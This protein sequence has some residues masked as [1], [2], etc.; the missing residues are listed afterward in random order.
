[1]SWILPTGIDALV[2][3]AALA[4]LAAVQNPIIPI[5]REREVGHIVDEASVDV[6]IVVPGMARLRLP[7]P[8]RR[9]ER[10]PTRPRRPSDRGRASRRCGALGRVSNG[11][12]IDALGRAQWVFYTS[13]STGYP[14]GVCHTDAALLAAARG[15]VDHLA[16]S[17]R[18]RS[19]VAFPIAHIGGPINLMASLLTGATLV[20]VEIFEPRPTSALL[21]RE[22]RDDGRL[23]HGVPSGLPGRAARTARRATLPLPAVLSGGRC[24]QATRAS[25]AGQSRARRG[26][27][28]L[29]LGLDRSTR[30]DH[31]PAL[32]SR[33]QAL[34]DRGHP[35]ARGRA[36]CGHADGRPA[37]PVSRASSGCSHLR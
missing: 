18:D 6:L 32:G 36:A 4:R 7:R 1:M 25:R 10:H 19:G 12:L 5:Y 2:L 35:V 3:A 13:G 8:R 9:P 26:R 28:R 16:I 27:H 29:E 34:C 22:E 15:M 14:K 31:G 17:E 23:G 24:A 11:G 21:A 37:G 20:L 33:R 30:A